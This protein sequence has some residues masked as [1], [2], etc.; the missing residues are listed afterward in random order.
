VSAVLDASAVR[1]L[2]GTLELARSDVVPSG[3]KRNLAFV[4]PYLDPGAL[5][6]PELQVLADAQTSGGL[7][8]VAPDAERM[9]RAL[10]ER[11]VPA[12]R[13]GRTEP[14]RP[15]RI[16]LRARIGE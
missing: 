16:E 8:I 3:T 11:G 5:S 4:R 9:E 14:G 7:L 6:E 10:I 2:P 15:G 1:L 12:V 13:I